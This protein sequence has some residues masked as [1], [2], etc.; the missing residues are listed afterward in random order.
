[1]LWMGVFGAIMALL[2]AASVLLIFVVPAWQDYRQMRRMV[3]TRCTILDSR[4]TEEQ[5]PEMK[6]VRR[7]G[8][9]EQVP[10][11]RLISQFKPE[12]LVRYDAAG[13]SFERWA[14]RS[15][16]FAGF[17]E[18]NQAEQVIQQYS[19]GQQYPCWYD[20]QD[21]EVVVLDTGGGFAG[22]VGM[23]VMAVIVFGSAAAFPILMAVLG[24]VARRRNRQ[25]NR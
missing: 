19:P 4:L 16:R 24:V 6:S 8:R 14:Y 1:M 15:P 7:N 12:F 20:P 21:P 5:S 3:E 10:T 13:S 11:G 9:L 22:V 18:R 25:S 17:A 23:V 2:F